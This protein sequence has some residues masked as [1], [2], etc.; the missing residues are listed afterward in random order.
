MNGSRSRSMEVLH[1]VCLL[2][3]KSGP[4]ISVD[5]SDRE[6]GNHVITFSADK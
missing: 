5:S 6:A 2:G 4:G 1:I 3:T